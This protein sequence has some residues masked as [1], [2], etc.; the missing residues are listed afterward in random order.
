MQLKSTAA[1]PS[2]LKADQAVPP[3]DESASDCVEGIKV[4]GASTKFPQIGNKS[5]DVLKEQ[6]PFG[7][8]AKG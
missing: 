5:M 6:R 8:R 2:L 4:D 1:S 7:D 3:T